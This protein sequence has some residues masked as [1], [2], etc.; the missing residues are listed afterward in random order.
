MNELGIFLILE[1]LSALIIY[2]LLKKGYGWIHKKP[3]RHYSRKK[4]K[5]VGLELNYA[6]PEVDDGMYKGRKFGFRPAVN[7]IQKVETEDDEEQDESWGKG[8]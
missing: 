2:D 4:I 7:K 1:I 3:K 6:E 8:L 5:P